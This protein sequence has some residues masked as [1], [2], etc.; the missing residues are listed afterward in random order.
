MGKAEAG[1]SSRNSESVLFESE[2]KY[3]FNAV[4]IS[5]PPDKVSFVVALWRVKV[6]SGKLV[7]VFEQVKVEIQLTQR[8]EERV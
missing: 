6:A 7:S 2:G 5:V 1:Y 8:L 4:E 3:A